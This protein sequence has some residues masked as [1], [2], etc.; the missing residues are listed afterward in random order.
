[1]REQN[2]VIEKS[3]SGGTEEYRLA[4]TR[5]YPRICQLEAKSDYS[6]GVKRG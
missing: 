6:V 1:M 2:V 4:H 3:G 5:E